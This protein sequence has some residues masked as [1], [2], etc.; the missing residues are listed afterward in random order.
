MAF[1]NKTEVTSLCKSIK[2]NKRV[3]ASSCPQLLGYYQEVIKHFNEK[4]ENESVYNLSQIINGIDHLLE[5]KEL[6]PFG[7]DCPRGSILLVDCGFDNFGYEF[8]YIHPCVVLAQT[9]YNIYIA[10]CSSK[11]YNTNHP[12][13]L[14]VDS[15]DGFSCNTAI[16]MNAIRWCAKDRAVAIL[17]TTTKKVLDDIET[18]LLEHNHKFK[19]MMKENSRYIDKL[20]KEIHQLRQQMN[21][22][23]TSNQVNRQKDFSLV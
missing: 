4:M 9:H 15:S 18:Y 13:I 2:D 11:K 7:G 21:D 23:K 6:K 22:L 12:E 1:I 14:N 3:K 8:S 5:N 19:N 10:P 17:G 16:I 20:E